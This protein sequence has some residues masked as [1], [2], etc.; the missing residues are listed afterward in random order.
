[1]VFLIFRI[2]GNR[3]KKRPAHL[4]WQQGGSGP[5]ETFGRL[6]LRAKGVCGRPDVSALFSTVTFFNSHL[7]FPCLKGI[8]SFCDEEVGNIEGARINSYL[9]QP[10]HRRHPPHKAMRL[11]KSPN[12]NCVCGL[13]SEFLCDAAL[14]T[15]RYSNRDK[16]PRI[17]VTPKRTPRVGFEK[18][19]ASASLTEAVRIDFHPQSLRHGKR[20]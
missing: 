20:Y 15:R 14:V 3:G 19:Q 11:N 4:S 8:R 17:S 2:P 13:L 5:H 6:G 10:G 1:M 12:S 7:V 18:N 16:A 9:L